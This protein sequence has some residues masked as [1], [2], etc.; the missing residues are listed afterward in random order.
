LDELTHAAL[1]LHARSAVFARRVAEAQEIIRR[2]LES[3]PYVA[4]SGGKDSL[5]ALALAARLR[6]GI[7]A[8][9]YDDELEYQENETY[10]PVACR[11]LNATLIVQ[12]GGA[13]HPG[14]DG[15]G[16]G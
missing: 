3:N 12:I 13:N 7:T 11:A 16:H 15:S 2:S 6:P 10:I 14:P 4:F 8:L 9:W 5:V 1:L